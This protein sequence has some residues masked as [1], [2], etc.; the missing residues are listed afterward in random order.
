MSHFGLKGGGYSN[1]VV[2]QL[3]KYFLCVYSLTSLAYPAFVYKWIFKGSQ[4]LQTV[5]NKLKF[6][7]S[8][9]LETQIVNSAQLE[10]YSNQDGKF[11]QI[12]QDKKIYC[13]M[14]TIQ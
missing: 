8:K 11:I 10:K 6:N 1:I 9:S 5:F 13:S 2:L 12:Y 4:T 7:C 14:T 3:K